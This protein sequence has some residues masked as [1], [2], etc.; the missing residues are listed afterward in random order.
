MNQ[1]INQNKTYSTEN[2]ALATAISL[3]F[4]LESIDRANPRK[5]RFEFLQSK[6][7]D[8]LIE[9]FWKHEVRVE[10][11]EFFNALKA[12]KSRIYGEG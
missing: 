9:S 3:W 6:Q 5:V 1:S 10:P 2:L 8:E 4:P 7:L 11:L 12:L